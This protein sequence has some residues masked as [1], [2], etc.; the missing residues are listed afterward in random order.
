LKYTCFIVCPV[1]VYNDVI[2]I[3]FKIKT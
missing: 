3:V 2:K 1:I